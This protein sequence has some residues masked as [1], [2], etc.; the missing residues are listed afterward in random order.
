MQTKFEKMKRVIY[1]ET[2][3]SKISISLSNLKKFK[4]HIVLA[5]QSGA[6]VEKLCPL[7]RSGANIQLQEWRNAEP[8]DLRRFISSAAA[9][10]RL[11]LF[12]MFS[13][14]AAGIKAH[15]SWWTSCFLLLD[16]ISRHHSPGLG[17]LSGVSADGS[18]A[19]WDQDIQKQIPVTASTFV[20]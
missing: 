9:T 13:E 3:L 8:G 15:V 1:T 6:H 12:K 17:Y 14:R 5:S 19:R 18:A 4:S 11:Q 2:L 20:H 10:F 16:P 7:E